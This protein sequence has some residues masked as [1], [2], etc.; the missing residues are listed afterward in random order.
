MVVLWVPTSSMEHL[1]YV[2]ATLLVHVTKVM[3]QI[4]QYWMA[5][6]CKHEGK[7]EDI[8]QQ[9]SC[10]RT[11]CMFLEAMMV[12]QAASKTTELISH[13]WWCRLWARITSRSSLTG[14]QSPPFGPH[15]WTLSANKTNVCLFWTKSAAS[16]RNS[17]WLCKH[18]CGQG[19]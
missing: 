9:E 2:V 15:H 10:T 14:M 3:C 13:R 12:A 1:L 7:K 18:R 4:H 8:L 5:T 19:D 6:I 17:T 11:S 16:C